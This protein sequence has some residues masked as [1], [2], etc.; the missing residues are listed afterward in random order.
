MP[1]Y[2]APDLRLVGYSDADWGGDPDEHKF[3]SSYASYSM[4]EPLLGA[5]RSKPALHYPLWRWNTLL[6]PRLFTR[7]FG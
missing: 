5:A 2:Q 7:V 1:Y 3:T 6:V 4:A